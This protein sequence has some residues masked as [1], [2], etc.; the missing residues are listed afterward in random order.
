MIA[1]FLITSMFHIL[2]AMLMEDHIHHFL[3]NQ[4]LVPTDV[5]EYYGLFNALSQ[6]GMDSTITF[7]R[8]EYL[9]G[10]IIF[11]F[12]FADDYSNGAGINGHLTPIK[13]GSMGIK[14]VFSKPLPEAVNLLV[15]CEFDNTIQIDK[16]NQVTT[17]Y[18]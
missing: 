12:N 6:T 17:D 4:I 10:K 13:R 3:T 7:D 15:Y 1:F 18:N 8:K 14:V 9:K 16:D 5:R 11:G 2:N